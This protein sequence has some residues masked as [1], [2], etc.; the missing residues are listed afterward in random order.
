MPVSSGELQASAE[1]I[2]QE[3]ISVGTEVTSSL[4]AKGQ[5]QRS[6]FSQTLIHRWQVGFTQDL[7]REVSLLPKRFLISLSA[8]I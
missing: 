1:G 7:L 3:G 2:L 8:A 4:Q 5:E 6:A